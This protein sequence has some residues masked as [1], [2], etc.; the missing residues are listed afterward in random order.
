M[1]MII[2]DVRFF[3]YV[4]FLAFEIPVKENNLNRGILNNDYYK[5]LWLFLYAFQMKKVSTQGQF[6]TACK[7]NF[8]ECQM[9]LNNIF[10]KLI[11][12]NMFR[13][14]FKKALLFY[15]LI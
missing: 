7:D 3:P 12:E 2:I 9:T 8:S 6:T 1:R 4:H 15:K 14:T 11:S 13:I 10:S 5:F